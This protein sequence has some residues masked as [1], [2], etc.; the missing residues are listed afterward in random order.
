MLLT[1]AQ[2]HQAM[3]TQTPIGQR[4]QDA[5]NLNDAHVRLDAGMFARREST[6]AMLPWANVDDPHAEYTRIQH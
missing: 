1:I 5:P 2:N 6:Q 4:L 3:A